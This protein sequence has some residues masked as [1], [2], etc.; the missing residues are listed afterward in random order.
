MP[1][2]IN[3]YKAKNIIRLLWV[4]INSKCLNSYITI[5]EVSKYQYRN[6]PKWLQ[7]KAICSA[8]IHHD[9]LKQ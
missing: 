4:K 8:P 5:K 6:I 9:S 3:Q 7:E 2:N 1:Q